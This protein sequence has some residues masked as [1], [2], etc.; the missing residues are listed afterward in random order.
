MQDQIDNNPRLDSKI[1]VLDIVHFLTDSWKKLAVSAQTFDF[2]KLFMSY[3]KHQI[4]S[5][6]VKSEAA[7][8]FPRMSLNQFRQILTA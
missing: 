3:W 8:V 4:A 2:S 7:V 5:N 1:P 6:D